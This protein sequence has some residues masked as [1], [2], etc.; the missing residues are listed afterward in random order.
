MRGL[1]VELTRLRWRRAVLLLLVAVVVLPALLLTTTAWNTR[2]MSE[3]EIDSLLSERYAQREV[4]RCERRPEQYVDYSGEAV[5]PEGCREMIAGWYGGRQTLRPAQELDGTVLAAS[6]LVLALVL[7]KARMSWPARLF[8]AWF[9]PRG[10]NSLLLALLLVIADV[11][12]AE[13]L[14]ATVGVVVGSRRSRM[15]GPHCRWPLGTRGWS[16]RTRWWRSA[17]RWPRRYSTSTWTPLTGSHLPSSRWR[18]RQ[19]N[20]QFLLDVRSHSTY[21]DDLV[22]IPSSV[23]VRPDEMIKWASDNPLDRQVAAYCT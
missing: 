19:A 9:G 17:R 20:R 4:A 3:A 6:T 22:R 14:L 1:L 15:G 21:E 2:P 5:E 11:P 10:L 7:L 16:Q 23:R 13:A 8:I 12:G 18:W